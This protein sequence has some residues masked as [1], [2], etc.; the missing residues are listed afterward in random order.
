MSR[1]DGASP[2]RRPHRTHGTLAAVTSPASSSR[3]KAAALGA[4]AG[5]TLAGVLLWRT[6][7]P[8]AFVERVVT[9][10]MAKP[11]DAAAWLEER[12]RRGR[13]LDEIP[14]PPGA[15]ALVSATYWLSLP[16]YRMEIRRRGRRCTL[17][18]HGVDAQTDGGGWTAFAEGSIDADPGSFRGAVARLSWWCIG[19]RNRRSSMGAARLTFS[20]DGRAVD[21]VYLQGAEA[22]AIPTGDTYVKAYGRLDDGR[23]PAYG[24]LRGQIPYTRAMK[25]HAG[26][27]RIRVTGVVRAR[28]GAPIRDAAVQ[29]QGIDRTRVHSDEAGRFQLE[30]AGRDAPWS[31]SICAGAPGFR[32]GETVLFT[33]DP[34]DGLVVEL[35]PIDL[36]DHP[37]YRWIH[38]APD[39]DPDDAQACGTCHAWQYAEWQGSRHGRMAENGHVIFERARMLRAGAAAPDD[40]A[41]CHQ[42]A[43]AAASGRGDYVPRGMAASNHCDFCHKIRHTADVRA[44]G[45]FG[46]LVLA[47]PDPAV[48][49]RPGDIHRVFGTAPDVTY[50]YMGASY[51]PYLGTSFL[52]AG[53]HQGGGAPGRPK[54]DTFEEWRRWAATREDE[55][56]RSCQDCHMPGGRTKNVD[57][58]RFDLFAWETLHRTPAAV[59]AHD[60]QGTG[61]AFA[62]DALDVQVTKRFTRGDRRLPVTV[63]VTNRGA[64]H[65]IPTGTSTKH[66]ALGV[67]ARA[68]DRWLVAAPASPRAMLGDDAAPG[69]ALSAG[70]WRNPPGLVLG[71]FDRTN[72][73]LASDFWAPPAASDVDDRRLEPEATRTFEVVFDLPPDAPDVEPV[74]EVRVIHRRRPLARGPESI[75]YEPRPYDAAPELLWSRIVR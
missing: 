34:G 42:P 46:S 40:C 59:H 66:V 65:S 11:E 62:K 9:R 74:V 68:G 49:D 38:P 27:A 57:G 7:G 44:P 35:E 6:R 39:K 2:S 10:P 23:T 55:R 51:S 47:R 14:D 48:R 19:L 71:V 3:R 12:D 29:L 72:G 4:L 1:P 67:W 8:E 31:Q 54:I 15:G 32:N 60:F 18:I 13:P 56:F 64:G 24:E 22:L 75:P 58:K 43:Y 53:C 50:A 36:D 20:S 25:R 26:D 30:F 73:R 52:C 16:P 61:T 45:V 33:G 28:D 69:E 63:S 70:D 21:A 17:G 37:A 5:L 41:A